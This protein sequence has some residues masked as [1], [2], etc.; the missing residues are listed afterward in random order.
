MGKA[1]MGKTGSPHVVWMSVVAV[2]VFRA[3]RP[4]ADLAG[5]S[6]GAATLLGMIVII[7]ERLRP[8]TSNGDKAS[9]SC[10]MT[11]TSP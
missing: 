5:K 10:K 3:S 1:L 4:A 2:E 11:S 7:D 6:G 9:N 8:E